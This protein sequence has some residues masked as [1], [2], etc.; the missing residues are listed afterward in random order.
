[1]R[2]CIAP[3]ASDFAGSETGRLDHPA[4]KM[5]SNYLELGRQKGFSEAKHL[6]NWL[7]CVWRCCR[8]YC[9]MVSL[10]LVQGYLL[11]TTWG[12]GVSQ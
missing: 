5:P 6:G 10:S 7:D 12:Y 9:N 1:M 3:R 11:E 2:F 4:S 8:N